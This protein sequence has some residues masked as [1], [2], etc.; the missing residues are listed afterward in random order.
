MASPDINKEITAVV[1]NERKNCEDPLLTN[2]FN[3]LG[4]LHGI[5]AFVSLVIL[6]VKIDRNEN[7]F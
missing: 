7:F 4:C 1:K 6:V 2:L 5:C 3:I